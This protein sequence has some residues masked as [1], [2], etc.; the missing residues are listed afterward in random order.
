MSF[1]TKMKWTA[2]I[3]VTWQRRR[4]NVSTCKLHL[5][6]LLRFITKR[7][8]LNTQ[9]LISKNTSRRSTLS[10]AQILMTFKN[11]YTKTIMKRSAHSCKCLEGLQ[12]IAS[13]MS[14]SK[15]NHSRWLCWSANSGK[16]LVVYKRE[17]PQA[18]QSYIN[19]LSFVK[20]RR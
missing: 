3:W 2:L 18:S 6:T 17:T 15:K 10:L 19:I 8:N 9:R 13:A 5:S 4:G 7:K 16:E 1:T 12:S 20:I 14:P 11:F